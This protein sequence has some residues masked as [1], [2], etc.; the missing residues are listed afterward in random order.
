[1]YGQCTIVWIYVV[2]IHPRSRLIVISS[3]AYWLACK[4]AQVA[5]Q[6]VSV[7]PSSNR[8]A[9]L[10]ELHGLHFQDPIAMVRS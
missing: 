2:S 3:G 6:S 1:M 10:L 7:Y 8:A 5:T 9:R 4:F